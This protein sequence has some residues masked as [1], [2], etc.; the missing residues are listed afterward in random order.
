M[1]HGVVFFNIETYISGKK[2][3]CTLLL[4]DKPRSWVCCYP[5]TNHWI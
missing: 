4:Y 1:T 5:H 2:L 3:A